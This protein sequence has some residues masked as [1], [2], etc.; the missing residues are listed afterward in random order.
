MRSAATSPEPQLGAMAVADSGAGMGCGVVLGR[1]SS[2]RVS[3]ALDA[4]RCSMCR[5]L[6]LLHK[7]NSCVQLQNSNLPP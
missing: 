7:G 5:P 6:H 2:D 1:C 3:S 4:D